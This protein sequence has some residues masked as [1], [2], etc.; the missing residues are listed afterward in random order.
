MPHNFDAVSL[1][2]EMLPHNFAA[3]SSQVLKTLAVLPTI[4]PLQ[5]VKNHKTFQN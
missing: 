3:V 5:N 1:Q 4:S 2:L